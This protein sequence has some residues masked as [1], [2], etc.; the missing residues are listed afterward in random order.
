M[1]APVSYFQTSNHTSQ[2]CSIVLPFKLYCDSTYLD[3]T[4]PNALEVIEAYSNDASRM[5]MKMKKIASNKLLTN[6]VTGMP[7]LSSSIKSKFYW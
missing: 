2:L 7:K 6:N 5:M 4:H 1:M 3:K